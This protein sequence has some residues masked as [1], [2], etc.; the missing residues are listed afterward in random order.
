MT[1]AEHAHV[2]PGMV[3]H[4]GAMDDAGLHGIQPNHPLG[5]E[6]DPA[7]D[8]GALHAPPAVHFADHSAD[9]THQA[10]QHEDLQQIH[11][12]PD[13]GPPPEEHHHG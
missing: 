1:G 10:P 2:D 11:L 8:Y 4:Q 3:L 12:P 13:L 7:V 6:H 5:N 9:M